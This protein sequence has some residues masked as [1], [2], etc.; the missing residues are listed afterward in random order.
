MKIFK[1]TLLLILS[2]L[3]LSSLN[4]ADKKKKKVT[5]TKK[6]SGVVTMEIERITRTYKIG[7][8][9]VSKSSS[10]HVAKH[11]GKQVR[12]TCDIGVCL[13]TVR[14]PTILAISCLRHDFIS[15][16]IQRL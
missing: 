13:D 9:K 1:I 5:E 14:N 4:A 12:A 6:I 7:S 2:L 10:K 15:V 3:F 8:I 16:R 11:V